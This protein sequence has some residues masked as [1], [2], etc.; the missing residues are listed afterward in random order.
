MVRGRY[1]HPYSRIQQIVAEHDAIIAALREHDKMK[2]K[3]A[4]DAH[5]NNARH[6]LVA[7]YRQQLK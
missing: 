7:Q 5:A 6:S 2:L 3:L 4:T 1:R